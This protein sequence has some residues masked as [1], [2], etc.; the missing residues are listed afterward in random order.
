[1]MADTLR[2]TLR[3]FLQEAGLL[4]PDRRL[5]VALSGGPDSLCLLHLLLQLRMQGG[6]ALHVAHLDHGIRGAEAEAEAIA[7]AA[8]AE[9]WGLPVVVERRDVPA[10]AEATGLGLPAAARLARYAFLAEVAQRS[11]V[12]GVAVAHQ[13]DDQAETLLLHALRGAGLAGLRG[14]RP[15]VPWAEWATGVALTAAGPPLIRPLLQRS[16]AEILA[17]CAT[18]GLEP[19]DDPSNRSPRYARTRIRRILATLSSENPRL[20]AALGRTAQLCADDY[21]YL[22]SQLSTHWPQLVTEGHAQISFQRAAWSMLH[23]SLQ[24]LALRRAVAQLGA[25]EPSMAQVEAAR[26]LT[27]M[28]GRQMLV[29]RTLWLRVD[30]HGFVLARPGAPPTDRVPQLVS[31]ELTLA[32]PGITALGAG[33]Y[34]LVGSAAPAEAGAWWLALDGSRLT[35]PLRLRRRRPGDRFRP[36]GATGSRKIQDFF[37]DRKVPR[38]LRD[39]WPLLV[40]AEAIVWVTGLRADQ[41]FLAQPQVGNLLWVGLTHDGATH[42]EDAQE[43]T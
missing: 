29:G 6:P 4:H 43:E 42:P 40:D 2:D 31:D 3:V 34:C 17:Y 38:A 21:D 32:W 9:A 5:L 28:A 18:H 14:M 19:F 27:R 10:L 1:M 30:Q 26:A 7:V 37:V 12:H 33:W 20:L 8:Q 25:D 11:A 13:A 16:R 15:L 24:R 36:E 39:A 35:G 41:R 23:P 22:Q